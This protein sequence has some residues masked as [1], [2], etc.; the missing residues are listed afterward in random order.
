MN[1]FSSIEFL[2][3]TTKACLRPM[4]GQR[5]PLSPCENNHVHSLWLILMGFLASSDQILLLRSARST[6]DS[7]Y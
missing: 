5:T 4:V 2:F 3:E 6:Q 1:K 7:D